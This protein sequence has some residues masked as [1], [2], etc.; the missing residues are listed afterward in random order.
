MEN[1][2]N[3]G[4]REFQLLKLDAIK[5]YH[6]ARKMGPILPDIFAGLGDAK[7]LVS[8]TQE[9]QL[10]ILA[11]L[12]SPLLK[13]FSKLSEEDSEMILFGLLQGAEVKGVGGAW[14]RVARPA[15]NPLDKAMLCVELEL[16]MLLQV[17]G[18]A[19]MF[20][21]SGFFSALP[22]K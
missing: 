7:K 18:R 13:E 5:Q 2:F 21:L 11:K 9:E 22:A 8:A 12:A 6:I 14:T 15:S 4:G 3:V 20:N 19:F 16:P 1:T 10:E 17:A